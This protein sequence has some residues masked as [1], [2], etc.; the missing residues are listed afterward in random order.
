MITLTITI[1][2]DG[3][4]HVRMDLRGRNQN[5]TEA[6]RQAAHELVSLAVERRAQDMPVLMINYDNPQSQNERKS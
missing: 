5:A 4:D 2:D 6:E 3:A 1:T